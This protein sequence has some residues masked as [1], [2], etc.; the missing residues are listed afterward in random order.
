MSD[1]LSSLA[2]RSLQQAEVVRPRPVALFESLPA[3]GGLRL[4]SASGSGTPGEPSEWALSS[5]TVSEAGQGD[6]GERSMEPPARRRP[7]ASSEP[8]PGA[9]QI[10]PHDPALVSPMT[11]G[12]DASNQSEVKSPAEESRSGFHIRRRQRQS[13]APEQTQFEPA[14]PASRAAASS[15]AT[16]G[17]RMRRAADERVIKVGHA[18]DRRSA[19]ERSD[20]I[21][22]PAST[23]GADH[24][25]LS[26]AERAAN[27]PR[28]SAPI[29]ADAGASAPPI[30]LTERRRT[31][32]EHQ[33]EGQPRRSARAEPVSGPEGLTK[34]GAA[35]SALAEGAVR[36]AD[37][38]GVAIE[39]R[40][41][42]RVE[43][44]PWFDRLTERGP[45]RLGL[46]EG[47]TGPRLPRRAQLD[48]EPAHT[49]NVTIGRLEVRAT[50]APPPPAPKE[51]RAGPPVMSLDEYLRQ[52]R[53][54]GGR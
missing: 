38:R 1:F 33:L 47:L 32:V 34:G 6:I 20:A 37:R 41:I 13:L 40:V 19:G 52:R 50:Q 42:Q 7:L 23:A 45:T 3:A 36:P 5:R 4:R 22:A 53:D 17:A 11:Q 29:D 44:V 9:H 16:K 51:E 46:A 10:D 8:A 43:P 18:P 2:A 35:P 28:L 49:I 14:S 21:I 31:P 39:P 54:G 25:V 48:D 30:P 12:P 15:E 27:R 24:P 26:E